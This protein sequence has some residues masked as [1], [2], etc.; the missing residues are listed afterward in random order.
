MASVTFPA[1]MRSPMVIVENVIAIALN[2]S[3]SNTVGTRVANLSG[4][5]VRW[6]AL[7]VRLGWHQG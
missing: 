6:C 4:H 5:E 7:K 3:H 2:A 1:T